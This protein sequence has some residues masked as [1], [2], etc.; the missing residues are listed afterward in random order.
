LKNKG[1]IMQ[2][3]KLISVIILLAIVVYTSGCA[4]SKP[5]TVDKV[6]KPLPTPTVESAVESP[7]V[8]S[9]PAIKITPEMVAEYAKIHQISD[10][11]KAEFYITNPEY[12]KAHPYV[13]TG[14]DIALY[15]REFLERIYPDFKR[16]AEKEGF[17]TARSMYMNNPPAGAGSFWVG[18]RKYTGMMLKLAEEAG[19]SA[20]SG[21]S[22][23]LLNVDPATVNY[24]KGM[25][26]YKEGKT[27]E[28]ISYLEKAI[29]FK[30]DSP[31]LHYN[32][33]IMYMS[34]DDS[35]KAIQSFQSTIANIKSTGYSNV[36]LKLYPDAFMGASTNL[37]MLY[38]RVGLYDQAVEVLK[39][40]VLFRPDDAYANLNLAITYYTMG[41]MDKAHEQMQKYIKLE[42]N[43]AEAYNS[44]GLIFYRKEQYEP[45][46][47]E[48]R[49]AKELSKNNKQYS[50]NEGLALAKLGRD[51]EAVNAFKASSG[52]E[53]GEEMRQ[54]FIQEFEA[55]KW[56][57]LYNRGHSTMEYGNYRQAIEL[58]KSAIEIKPD[59]LEAYVNLGFCYRA[60]GDNENQVYYF[61]KAWEL[62][63]D[64]ADIN[65]NLGLAYSDS[66]MYEKAIERFNKV[67]ELNPSSKE[68][69]FSIGTAYYKLS[70]YANAAEAFKKA[71][72]LSP[73]W[74]EARLNLGSCYLKTGDVKGATTQFEEAI[75]GNPKSAEAYYNLGIAYMKVERLNEAGAMFQKTIE[76]NPG[77]NMAKAMLKE[78]ER[79]KQ[80]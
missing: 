10:L 33:G 71:V 42:P 50:Y 29:V 69:Y 44:L 5:I 66:K 13:P 75:K 62:S 9:K 57:E 2:S 64:S 1:F 38:T 20:V 27:D 48:F 53:E 43:N 26:L 51:E 60:I 80:Q 68:A 31:T 23:A 77:H 73:D 11:K 59:V 79:Y 65:Y 25:S 14:E 12:A 21:E 30:P 17:M 8:E 46:L 7:P 28:A 41:N 16:L 32:I 67:A 78:L 49:K 52:L 47:E 74:L 72:D 36:N 34:K 56:R 55:N 3:N 76:I 45:A 70:K 6:D 58:F 40:A 4:T 54:Q 37:G 35:P 19:Q 39:E 63:P 18:S 15:E 22:D 61:R 24:Q